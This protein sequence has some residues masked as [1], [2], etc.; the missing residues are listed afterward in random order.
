MTSWYSNK[1]LSL[2]HSRRAHRGLGLIFI[3]I[4]ASIL[5]ISFAIYAFSNM[6]SFF[7]TPSQ[8]IVADYSSGHELRLGGYVQRHS[9]QPDHK[10]FVLTDGDKSV[11]ILY[12]G[13][14][15]V[16]FREGQ[17][18]IVQGCFIS[19]ADKLYRFKAAAI[20]VKHDETYRALR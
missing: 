14:L 15:P 10:R 9:F 16:L 20:L 1:S 13:K 8:L 3:I 6:I 2:K 5:A 11:V 4:V 18:V 7:K 17:G 19:G 12:S